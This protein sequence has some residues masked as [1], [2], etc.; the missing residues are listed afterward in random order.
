MSF[1]PPSHILSHHSHNVYH[2]QS[3]RRSAE[4]QLTWRDTPRLL[5]SLAHD[6]V[7]PALDAQRDYRLRSPIH[8][9][10]HTRKMSLLASTPPDSR[11]PASEL[12]DEIWL[13]IF[14]HLEQDHLLA[15]RGINQRLAK[16][17]LAPCLHRR[18][19]LHSLPPLPLPKMLVDTILPSLEHLHLHLFPF[20]ATLNREPHPSKVLLALLDAIPANR[21][22]SLSLPFS[23]PYLP[24][25]ELGI[26]LRRIGGRL[27][28]LDLKGSG[29][30]GA[31]YLEWMADIGKSGRGLKELDLAFTSISALPGE[32]VW[33]NLRRLS[34]ASCTSLSSSALSTFLVNLPAAIETLDIS[35][36]EQVT[37]SALTNLRVVESDRV[38]SLRDLKLVGIDHLTRVNVRTLKRHWEDQ[39][40]EVSPRR[41]FRPIF[42]PAPKVWGEPS[43][44]PRSAS[45]FAVPSNST[46]ASSDQPPLDPYADIPATPALTSR[47]SSAS[48]N[49]IGS[50]NESLTGTGESRFERMTMPR[51]SVVSSHMT[52]W[53]SLSS[54]RSDG[55]FATDDVYTSRL[56]SHSFLPSRSNPKPKTQ[57]AS[58]SAGQN[59]FRSRL[60][61]MDFDNDSWPRRWNKRASLGDDGDDISINITHSAILES[62]DEAGY[63]MFIGQVVGGTQP[64]PVAVGNGLGLGAVLEPAFTGLGLGVVG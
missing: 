11:S 3:T 52:L 55:L 25:T 21:L 32:G 58:P 44:S 19:I 28:K 63:R 39:R 34:I 43:Q 26:V 24:A 40:M 17:A 7:V 49:S 45:F 14:A 35:R 57:D 47:C 13:N 64:A 59:G 15:S 6:S 8:I 48:S 9:T 53:T 38:T 50:E 2:C 60:R 42:E 61:S 4:D 56:P 41:V 30:T 51:A 36:L 46:F 62:E 23:A 20:P 12:P 27:E 18:M 5:P 54:D 22:R 10:G 37:L 33:S 16:L 1:L 29:I 31:T